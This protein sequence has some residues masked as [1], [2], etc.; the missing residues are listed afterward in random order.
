[1]SDVQIL[2]TV[3]AYA[4]AGGVTVCAAGLVADHDAEV[5]AG[6]AAGLEWLAG[7]RTWLGAHRPHV[8]QKTARAARTTAYR[9]VHPRLLAPGKH[10][11]REAIA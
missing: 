3:L 10:R 11:R 6:W 7:S 9:A 8:P 2:A 1:M 5:R 4:T